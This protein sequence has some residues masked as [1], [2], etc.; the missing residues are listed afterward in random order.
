MPSSKMRRACSP[1]CAEA[2]ESRT[3]Y[4]SSPIFLDELIST[5]KLVRFHES[6]LNG[7][8]F[9]VE[10]KEG[11]VN[12]YNIDNRL[13]LDAT[14]TTG[15]STL[16][17]LGKMQLADVAISGSLK[18]FQANTSD[19]TGTMAMSGSVSKFSLGGVAGTLAI[20]GA[21]GVMQIG[22]TVAV[23]GSITKLTTGALDGAT[24]L[25]GAILPADSAN[26][27]TNNTYAGGSIGTMIVNGPV[28]SSAIAVG[29]SPGPDGIFGTSDDTSAGGGEIYKITLAGG[30]DSQ[31][32]VEAGAFGLVKVRS[33]QSNG[34]LE[35]LANP[36]S[37]SN[38]LIPPAAANT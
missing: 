4:S 25:D 21:V 32:H 10:I 23:G 11:I 20:A 2:L 34:P 15:D 38:F 12:I 16:I 24:F 30:A 31:S 26:G 36:L 9:T 8:P 5:K 33:L 18:V 3:L 1:I 37:D 17:V 35:T 29:V 6:S 19:V 7:L 14:N 13:E 27:S 28:Y 22:G